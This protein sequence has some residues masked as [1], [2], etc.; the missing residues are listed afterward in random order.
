MTDVQLSD[1][2]SGAKY[3]CEARFHASPTLFAMLELQSAV[4]AVG[5]PSALC[6]WSWYVFTFA[7]CNDVTTLTELLLE[8]AC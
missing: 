8:L 6:A 3:G 7:G 5:T 1:Q 2:V 4:S